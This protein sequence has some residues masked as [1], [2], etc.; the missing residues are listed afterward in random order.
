MR[1]ASHA[2]N[3]KECTGHCQSALHHTMSEV[4]TT[5]EWYSK[6]VIVSKET[7]RN[8]DNTH[9]VIV[10]KGDRGDIGH[11]LQECRKG[12]HELIAIQISTRYNC[13]ESRSR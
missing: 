1:N 7:E 8:T 4:D 13:N 11:R 3:H 12:A 5:I 9:K 6:L 2:T 10:L